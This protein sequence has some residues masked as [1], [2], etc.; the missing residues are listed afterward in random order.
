MADGIPQADQVEKYT[1]NALNVEPL[2]GRPIPKT[3]QQSRMA[4]KLTYWQI[5]EVAKLSCGELI[6]VH[7][8]FVE[9]PSSSHLRGLITSKLCRQGFLDRPTGEE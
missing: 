9:L 4:H 2:T 7:H 8:P 5:H 3:K 6:G 1:Q